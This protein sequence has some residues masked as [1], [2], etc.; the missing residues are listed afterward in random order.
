MTPVTISE[1]AKD[2][3]RAR[4]A[5]S[6]IARPLVWITMQGPEGDVKRTSNG[7]VDWT[8]NRRDLWTLLVVGDDRIADDDPR[9]VLVDGL[10]FVSDFFP[11]RFEVSVKD[12]TFRVAAA[13]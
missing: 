7:D 11:I 9:L 3:L 4:M 8:I 10:P 1:D 12:G 6:G 13:A 5:S 2:L